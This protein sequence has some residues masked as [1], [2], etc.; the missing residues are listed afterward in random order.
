M[1][2]ELKIQGQVKKPFFITR[3]LRAWKKCGGEVWEYSIVIALS[4]GGSIIA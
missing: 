4:E 3:L 1:L 2:Q